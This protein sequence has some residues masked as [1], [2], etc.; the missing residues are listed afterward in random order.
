MTDILTTAG[1]TGDPA[2]AGF[3][4][5]MLGIMLALV[6]VLLLLKAEEERKKALPENPR[7]ARRE[8][9]ARHARLQGDLRDLEEQIERFRTLEGEQTDQTE[10]V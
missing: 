4:C 9:E 2:M 8:L 3:A 7:D 1:S 5:F 10:A 6:G